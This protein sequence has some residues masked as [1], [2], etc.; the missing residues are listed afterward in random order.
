MHVDDCSGLS[1]LKLFQAGIY[2]KKNEKLVF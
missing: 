2:F 1:E